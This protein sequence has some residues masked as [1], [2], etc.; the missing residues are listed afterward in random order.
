MTTVCEVELMASVVGVPAV[1]EISCDRLTVF[2]T[3]EESRKDT[4]KVKVYPLVAAVPATTRFGNLATPSV[5]G[6]VA[7]EMILLVSP[8]KVIVT[9]AFL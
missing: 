3:F 1:I 4:E 6:A 9:V 7:P 2:V 5:V 8:V